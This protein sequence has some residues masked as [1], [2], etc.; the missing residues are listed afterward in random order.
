MQGDRDYGFAT[1]LS[2]V[3]ENCG[4]VASEWSSRRI[5]SAKRCNP[6]EVNIL[7]GRAM[8]STGN[9]ETAMNDIFA[10]MGL[11]GRAMHKKTFHG[12]LKN[13][14]QP[15]ATRAAETAMQQCAREVSAPYE[16]LWFDHRNNIT[17][18][19]DG[20]WMTRGHSSHIG[21]GAVELF[22]GYV[23]DYVVLISAWAAK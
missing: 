15:A 11:S 7:A 16:G 12:H 21:V 1:K 6:F 13:T 23:L 4:E 18:C 2:L 3:C 9:G 14:L 19:F 17:V 5:D 8:L 20:M 10:A 22:T